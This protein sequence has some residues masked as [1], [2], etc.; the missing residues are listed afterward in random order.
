MDRVKGVFLILTILLACTTTY[1]FLKSNSQERQLEGATAL[2]QR[3]QDL[4]RL[5]DVRCSAPASDMGA[6]AEECI[7]PLLKAKDFKEDG[8]RQPT[9]KGD[10]GYVVIKNINRKAYDAQRFTFLHNRVLTQTGCTISGEIGYEV[11]CRFEFVENCKE[12]DVLEVFYPDA[13]TE[14][15]VKIFLKTC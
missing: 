5:Q 14:E 6:V 4:L 11:T 7:A 15:P 3:T 2:S 12:G 1:L 13:N 8:F 9:T 10:P